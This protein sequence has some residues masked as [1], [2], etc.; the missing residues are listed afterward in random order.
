MLNGRYDAGVVT[1]SIPPSRRMPRP[2]RQLRVASRRSCHRLRPPEVDLVASDLGLVDS[3]QRL[4]Q[5]GQLRTEPRLPGL[6]WCFPRRPRRSRPDGR[7]VD[8][9]R[10]LWSSG[11]LSRR[12]SEYPV[13]EWFKR[14]YGC[15][16]DGRV[17]FDEGPV[18]YVYCVVAVVRTAD[19]VGEQ[20]DPYNG[21]NAYTVAECQFSPNTCIHNSGEAE[22]T[23]SQTRT[24]SRVLSSDPWVPV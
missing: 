13:P 6:R 11:A 2:R 1:Q 12:S 19:C 23:R 20:D 15:T 14:H 7:Q 17:D 9:V 21:N 24:Q 3:L 16:N 8:V 4:V 22:R 18:V 5:F 10:L